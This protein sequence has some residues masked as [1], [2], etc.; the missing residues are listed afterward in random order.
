MFLFVLQVGIA[1]PILKFIVFFV[2]HLCWTS[3]ANSMTL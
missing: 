1:L 2:R 3:Y